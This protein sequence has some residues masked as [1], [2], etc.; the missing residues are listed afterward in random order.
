MTTAFVPVF[1]PDFIPAPLPIRTRSS[2]IPPAGTLMRATLGDTT[3]VFRVSDRVSQHEVFS[4]NIEG[5]GYDHLREVNFWARIPWTFEILDDV[6][7]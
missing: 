2:N 7:E 4:G 5:G 3:I 6:T 1:D